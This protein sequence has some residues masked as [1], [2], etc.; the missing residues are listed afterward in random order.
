VRMFFALWPDEPTRERIAEVAS[1]LSWETCARP[2]APKNYHLT[3]AF[4]GEVSHAGLPTL[5]RC[6]QEQRVAAFD[7]AF[8]ACEYWTDPQVVVA[9][10]ELEPPP[11]RQLSARLRR[12]PR[13]TSPE[14]FRAHVTLARNV[15]QAHVPQAL[16]PFDWHA[17]SFCLIRSEIRAA[18]AVYTVVDTWSLL[19]KI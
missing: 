13:L 16:S 18:R 10:P 19:D 3:L 12:D 1:L 15:A 14:R 7:I 6:A 17:R 5:Q 11:L 4:L 2:V 9:V 8:G